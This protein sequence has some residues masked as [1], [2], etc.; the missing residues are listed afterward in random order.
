MK[1]RSGAR[2]SP[3]P[4]ATN[5]GY[6]ATGIV[7]LCNLNWER[8]SRVSEATIVSRY[9]PWGRGSRVAEATIVSRYLPWA[10]GSRVAEATI[11]SRYHPGARGDPRGRSHYRI[12]PWSAAHARPKPQL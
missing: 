9:L 10:R 5:K 6:F 11:V 12:T 4:E 1:I 8:G 2:D 3:R 7:R